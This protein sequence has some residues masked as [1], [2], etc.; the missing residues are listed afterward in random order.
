LIHLLFNGLNDILS[1]VFDL[2][3]KIS[4]SRDLSSSSPADANVNLFVHKR[5]TEA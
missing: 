3:A 5:L 1:A 2:M 4:R